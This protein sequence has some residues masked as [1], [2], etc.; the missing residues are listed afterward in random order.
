MRGIFCVIAR[1]ETTK[2]SCPMKNEEV[3]ILTFNLS[4][5]KSKIYFFI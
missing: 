1:S 5:I 3:Y 4:F 2:Q